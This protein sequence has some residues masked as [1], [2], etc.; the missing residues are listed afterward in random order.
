MF[1]NSASP[2]FKYRPKLGYYT[3]G[4]NNKFDLESF[5]AT[6]YK[7]WTY[8]TKIKGKVVFNSYPYSPTTQGHQRRMREL[9]KQLGIKIDVEVSM[10]QSLSNFYNDSLPSKYESLFLNEIALKRAKKQDR[11][12]SIN[13]SIKDL[14]AEIKTCRQL[15][16]K[17]PMASIVS[18]KARLIESDTKRLERERE[19][20]AEVKTLRDFKKAE[21]LDFGPVMTEFDKADSL[22]EIKL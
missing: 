2:G 11:I 16:A 22:D 13:E 17:M 20:R 8:V 10:R 4:Q 6:S 1:N 14:K 3:D 21:L 5:E 19:K 18:L 7:W 12:N 9:L 15:G